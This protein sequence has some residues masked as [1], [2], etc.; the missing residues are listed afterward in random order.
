MSVLYV[1]ATPIGNLG[2]ITARALEV[3]RGADVIAAEDTR[4]TQGLLA[5]FAIG[6][7]L[8]SV[9]EHNERAASESILRLLGEGKAVALV[10]D[11]GTPPLLRLEPIRLLAGSFTAG[12]LSCPSLCAQR[13][14]RITGGK[15]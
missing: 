11:A 5:H 7:K 14:M 9:R 3:L 4:V 13:P 12:R 8:V 1:V 6:A 15:L 2:D 10:S